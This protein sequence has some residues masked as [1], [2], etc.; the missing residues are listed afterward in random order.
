MASEKLATV[1]SSIKEAPISV[2]NEGVYWKKQTDTIEQQSR[3]LG[4]PMKQLYIYLM[5]Y[6]RWLHQH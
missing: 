5:D 4:K 6:L 3:L 2:K 1:T